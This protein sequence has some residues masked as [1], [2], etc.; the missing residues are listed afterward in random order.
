VTSMESRVPGWLT[1][2]CTK[3]RC[4]SPEC[5][6]E[7]SPAL[8]K[9]LCEES[10]AV[11]GFDAEVKL[12]STQLKAVEGKRI[13]VTRASPSTHWMGPRCAVCRDPQWALLHNSC[14][15][16]VCQ[17]CWV[18]WSE[19]QIASCEAGRREVGMCFAPECRELLALSLVGH[20]EL[21]STPLKSFG[22][23]SH[24]AQRRRLRSNPLFPGPLQVDCPQPGCWGLGYLG[25]ET[26]MCFICEHQWS[27]EGSEGE[28][29]STDATVEDVMGVKMKK[30]PKCCEY[31]EK[32]GGCDH[33][34]CR[35]QHQFWWSTLKP[36]N[37]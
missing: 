1:T 12:Q 9:V 33:M 8:W 23:K 28:G 25:F 3:A 7:V 22:S 19:S 10:Q 35:C 17:D 20:L 5:D 16:G 31:I 27:P 21:H 2:R 11:Q 24:V 13:Q 18:G 29:T 4:F 26:A 14:G 34:T 6:Q 15:H 32:N 37:R 30:C 36:Y